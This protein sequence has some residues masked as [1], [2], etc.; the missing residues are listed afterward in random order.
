[1]TTSNLTDNDRK[2]LAMAWHC[3]E[4]QPKVGQPTNQPKQS[5]TEPTPSPAQTY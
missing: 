1:M 5:K 4:T 3:F 2:M